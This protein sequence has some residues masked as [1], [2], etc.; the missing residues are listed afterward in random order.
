MA[1]HRA[2]HTATVLP[3]GLVLVAGGFGL[4]GR[5]GA[6]ELYDPARDLWLPTGSMGTARD[7]HTATLLPSG[8]V[9]VVGGYADSPMGSTPTDSAELYD[10]A[11]GTWS[12][13]A[14]S[15]QARV[16]HTATLLPSGK[17]L[18]AGGHNNMGM[19]LDAELY[20]P[21]A[22]TWTPAGTLSTSRS[23]HTALLLP[24]SGKVMVVG[25]TSSSTSTVDLY[26][27]AT[28]SWSTTY[29]SNYHYR[30]VAALLPSG[31]VLVAD[32]E[33]MP[34]YA[35]LYDPATDSWTST[36]SIG[37]QRGGAA[38]VVL[39]SGKVLVTGG[40][41]YMVP[42]GYIAS[43]ELYDPAVGT[44]SSAGTMAT[45]RTNFTATVLPSGIVL[46]AGGVHP[47][48]GGGGTAHNGVELFLP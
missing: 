43:A 24:S 10:P 27:L 41:D 14:S 11:S 9:L 45:A 8:K 18:V 21:A 35:E 2:G 29:M 22:N 5:P 40:Y 39:P 42:N 28:G 25:G 17:V 13:V 26:D 34:R 1:W 20:D 36:G 44:W 16:S 23:L 7:Y 15:R 31:K 37:V 32:T 6:S 12:A 19:V 38:A 47:S 33:G 3:S 30:G 46:V 4:S 48:T